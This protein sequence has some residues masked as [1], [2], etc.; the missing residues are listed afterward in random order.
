MSAEMIELFLRTGDKIQCHNA[1]EMW[2]FHQR[3][4]S[5]GYNLKCNFTKLQ[6][7]ILGRR[8]EEDADY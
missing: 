8:P 7:E 3:L 5:L 2:N 6:I 4:W 1:S